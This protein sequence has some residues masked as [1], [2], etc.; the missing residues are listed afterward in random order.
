MKK[1]TLLKS[2]TQADELYFRSPYTQHFDPISLKDLTELI[3]CAD[4]NYWDAS[5]RMV[6]GVL[7]VGVTEG[8]PDKCCER[9]GF[10]RSKYKNSN[11]VKVK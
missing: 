9:C 5:T 2:I 6:D 11:Y 10:S 8:K 7:M 1:K 4:Y 3:H